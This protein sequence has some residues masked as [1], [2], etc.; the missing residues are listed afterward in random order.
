MSGL[1]SFFSGLVGLYSTLIVIRIMFSWV[2]RGRSMDSNKI[3]MYLAKITDPYLNFFRGM[4]MSRAGTLDFS[5]VIALLVLN[6]VQS[7]LAVVGSYG[8][9][10]VPVLL[11]IVVRGMWE[12]LF[13]FLM[14]VVIILLGIRVFMTYTHSPAASRWIPMIDRIINKPVCWV[15]S[16]IYGN[17]NID[18]NRL[19]LTSLIFYT[20]LF[21]IIKIGLRSL[22]S[23]LIT[24]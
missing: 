14:L 2:M 5:P 17:K 16:L 23:W 3:T 8:K 1:F 9:I 24:I 15:W 4:K 11:V 20:V 19:A 13:R 21:F 6:I 18:E 22:L 12:Y 7:V 10:T